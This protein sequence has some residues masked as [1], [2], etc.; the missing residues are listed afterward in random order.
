MFD[1]ICFFPDSSSNLIIGVAPTCTADSENITLGQKKDTIGFYSKT[2]QMFYNGKCTGNMVG[3]RCS[4]GFIIYYCIP[5]NSN[6]SSWWVFDLN[7][8]LSNSFLVNFE[9]ELWV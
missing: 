4:K 3:H 1:K 8:K 9:F 6:S 5:G 2:G 7:F